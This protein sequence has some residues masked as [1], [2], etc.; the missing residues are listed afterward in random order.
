MLR[1]ALAGLLLGVC[2]V[3]V[4]EYPSAMRGTE[5]TDMRA[6][7]NMNTKFNPNTVLIQNSKTPV[8]FFGTICLHIT[9]V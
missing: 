7:K 4:V 6:N 8:F 3:V 9:D 5:H 2:R 1:D